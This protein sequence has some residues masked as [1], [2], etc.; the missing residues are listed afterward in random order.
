MRAMKTVTATAVLPCSA[1]TFWKVFL[2]ERYTRALF[3]DELGFRGFA[4]LELPGARA[5]SA[6]S[7][8]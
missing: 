3:L 7:P 8:T 1:E 2:D 5:R 4:V 6:S